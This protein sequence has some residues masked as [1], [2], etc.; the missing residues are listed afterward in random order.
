MASDHGWSCGQGVHPRKHSVAAPLERD[1]DPFP[2]LPT[3]TV[4]LAG[5][6]EFSGAI[7]LMVICSK[8]V[9]G[10]LRSLVAPQKVTHRLT[11]RS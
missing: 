5:S 10:L 7:S 6:Q 4:P 9:L 8:S 3:N 1:A 2:T 11:T